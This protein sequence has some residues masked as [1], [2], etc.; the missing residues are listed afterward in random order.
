VLSRN[1]ESLFV[2]YNGKTGNFDSENQLSFIPIA[3]MMKDIGAKSG[4]IQYKST[5]NMGTVGQNIQSNKRI[6]NSSELTITINL[7]CDNKWQYI[8][9]TIEE[10]NI[11]VYSYSNFKNNTHNFIV[12]TFNISH[13]KEMLNAVAEKIKEQIEQL[14]NRTKTDFIYNQDDSNLKKE[15]NKKMTERNC[16]FDIEHYYNK[17]ITHLFIDVSINLDDASQYTQNKETLELIKA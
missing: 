9:H 6:T 7:E 16:K 14:D 15:C 5:Q 12:K 17:I 3:V 10:T 4:A 1:Y 8:F 11:A 2:Q 13:H